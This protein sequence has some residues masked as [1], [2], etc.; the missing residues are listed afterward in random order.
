MSPPLPPTINYFDFTQACGKSLKRK[1][2][3]S[4]LLTSLAKSDVR[5]W[6]ISLS[7]QC[8][9]VRCL[10]ETGRN[11]F[12]LEIRQLVFSVILYQATMIKAHKLAVRMPI[13]RFLRK[14]DNGSFFKEQNDRQ[15]VH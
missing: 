4:V 6:F 15:V 9:I 3:I 1:S 12:F 2:Q 10:Q 11:Q 7:S 13:T 5:P 8:S 14:G